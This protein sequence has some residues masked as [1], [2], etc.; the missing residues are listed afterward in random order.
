MARFFEKMDF[1]EGRKDAAGTEDWLLLLTQEQIQDKI[2]QIAKEIESR[3]QGKPIVLTCI[4]KGAAWFMVHLS[5]Y[6]TIPYTTYFIEARSYHDAQTQ[7]EELKI[8]SV[9]HPEKFLGRTVIL[10]DELFDNG[11]TLNAVKRAIYKKLYIAVI[12]SRTDEIHDAKTAEEAK[13]IIHEASVKA[14]KFEIFTCTLFL[15]YK[16]TDQQ[17]PD[18]YGLRIPNVWVVGCGLDDRQEKRGWPV[19]FA[20]PKGE[21]IPKTSDDEIFS[22]AVK[23]KQILDD[24]KTEL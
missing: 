19:L 24:L 20:C 10:L 5:E 12:E 6:L 7:S 14:R 23:Y 17:L 2:K 13:R 4:L 3:Y 15:K 11:I 1:R 16:E 22:S 8:M 18:L 9:I 21:G